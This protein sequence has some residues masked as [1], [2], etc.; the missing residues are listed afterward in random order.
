M[1]THFRTMFLKAI[2][3]LPSVF[4][5][6]CDWRC[7]SHT[8]TTFL[9]RFQKGLAS[10]ILSFFFEL[11]G[12]FLGINNIPLPFAVISTR[13]W[14]QVCCVC[15]TLCVCVSVDMSSISRLARRDCVLCR[16]FPSF[17]FFFS[18]LSIPR[19]WKYARQRFKWR[20]HQF[21]LP[22][23][24]ASWAWHEREKYV[25]Y[26]FSFCVTLFVMLWQGM[27]RA[28]VGTP[29]SKKEFDWKWHYH[30]E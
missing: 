14:H 7:E 8:H 23:F 4:I 5:H 28:L 20:R 11:P 17:L 18:I 9:F 19:R 6:Q 1:S 24:F 13:W 29:F 12:S 21:S 15:D 22:F 3:F 30:K 10:G 26:V 27:M 25:K 2:F 16:R